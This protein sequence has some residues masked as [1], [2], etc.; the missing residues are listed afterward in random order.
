MQKLLDEFQQNL[1]G[2]WRMS[3]ESADLDPGMWDIGRAMHSFSVT[4]LTFISFYLVLIMEVHTYL[5]HLF[6]LLCLH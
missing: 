4:L 6:F 3:Q 2:G 1:E 5:M